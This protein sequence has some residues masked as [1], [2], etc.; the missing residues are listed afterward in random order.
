MASVRFYELR[1]QD[2]R[3]IQHRADRVVVRA[4]L[5][6]LKHAS[7]RFLA[8]QGLQSAE[9]REYEMVAADAVALLRTGTMHTGRRVVWRKT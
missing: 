9:V 5:E 4:T 3:V 2:Y 1:A 6:E 7:R 8:A